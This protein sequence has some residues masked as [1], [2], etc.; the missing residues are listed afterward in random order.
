MID[1]KEV[2]ATA[3]TVF[4]VVGA[5]A[6]G[7]LGE[8]LAEKQGCT[9]SEQ[10]T[11]FCVTAGVALAV[12]PMTAIAGVAT[13]YDAAKDAWTNRKSFASRFVDK[14]ATMKTRGLGKAA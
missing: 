2:A 13:T 3:F 11:A 1:W 5:L 4:T 12:A 7:K 6:A 10:H 14:F 9:E 8:H